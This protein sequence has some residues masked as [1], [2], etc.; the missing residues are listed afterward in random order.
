MTTRTFPFKNKM[1]H[2]FETSD[3]QL[4]DVVKPLIAF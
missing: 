4:R 3:R 1:E 2:A